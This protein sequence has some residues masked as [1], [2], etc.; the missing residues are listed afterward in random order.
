M[1]TSTQ[2]NTDHFEYFRLLPDAAGR[3]PT[4]FESFCP[5]YHSQDRLGIVSSPFEAAV[6]HTPV[7][8]LAWTTAFYDALR[9]RGGEFFNYPQHYAFYP[10]TGESV[11][12][13]TGPRP[14]EDVAI[15][16]WGHLDVWPGC[17]QVATPA[18][19]GGIVKSLFEYD[20][21]RVLWP[22]GLLATG[23][24][25]QINHNFRKMLRTRLKGVYL[26]N[27]DRPTIEIVAAEPPAKL[28]RQ[29]QAQAGIA[30]GIEGSEPAADY[31]EALE[32][33]EVDAFL[34][35]LGPVFES[36]G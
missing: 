18:T 5:N 32:Q 14:A 27:S 11:I 28:A 24:P 15:G 1:H 16:C 8:V 26:Y 25:P 17:K 10:V 9:A 2:L 3:L 23:E 7:A 4:G 34:E 31:V 6:R 35:M 19:V 33:I 12:T 13:E 21:N 20:V 30:D 36:A 22:A 29:T